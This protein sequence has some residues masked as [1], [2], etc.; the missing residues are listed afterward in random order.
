MDAY[1]ITLRGH[2]YSERVAARCIKT[3]KDIGGI[4]VQRF[5]AVGAEDA[6]RVMRCYG[7]KWTWGEGGA[8]LTHHSYGGDVNARIGCAMSHYVLWETCAYSDNPIIILEHDSVFIRPFKEFEFDGI[9][10]INDPD[11][12]TPRGKWWHDKMVERGDG[13]WPKTQVFNTNRPDGLAGNSAYVLKPRAALH[14]MELVRWLGVWP[15]DAIMC[16]QLVPDLEEHYPFITKVEP[17]QST[18][19][20]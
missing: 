15:N 2:E 3:G 7:F 4:D 5:D 9:C 19:N 13:V 8:G 10:Q 6:A 17:E 12:A 11:G 14:L 16:R 18:I 20:P 1:V